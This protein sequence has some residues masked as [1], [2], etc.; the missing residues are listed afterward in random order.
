[1][2]Q[3]NQQITLSVTY[4]LKGT[5]A[6]AQF[7]AADEVERAILAELNR[8]TKQIQDRERKPACELCLEWNVGTK[9]TP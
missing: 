9:V 3:P 6:K 5:D 2:S 8:I 4:T 7:R 1:M